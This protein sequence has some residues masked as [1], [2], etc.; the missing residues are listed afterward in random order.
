MRFSQRKKSSHWDIF[1]KLPKYPSIV[2]NIE[3]VFERCSQIGWTSILYLQI[4]CRDFFF[5][6]RVS[7]AR[8]AR[9][10][11]GCKWLVSIYFQCS[12][13]LYISIFCKNISMKKFPSP[14]YKFGKKL[15]CCN[16]LLL[17]LLAVWNGSC[18]F[19]LHHSPFTHLFT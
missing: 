9:F 16:Y 19:A 4:K 15:T 2:K 11:E 7:W 18:S 12:S 3:G 6:V 1:C 8:R 5:S 10:F 13:I 14:C 17:S